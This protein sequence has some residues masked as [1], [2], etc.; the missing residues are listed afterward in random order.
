MGLAACGGVWARSAQIRALL[1]L[2]FAKP[3]VC[4]RVA[5]HK[6]DGSHEHDED[7]SDSYK[8]GVECWTS[9]ATQTATKKE[10]SAGLVEIASDMEMTEATGIVLQTTGLLGKRKVGERLR[11]KTGAFLKRLL[12][13]KTNS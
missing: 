11:K 12:L 13:S 3:M 7:N 2:R 5:F 4:M 1:N 9:G 8:E 10:L 6:N